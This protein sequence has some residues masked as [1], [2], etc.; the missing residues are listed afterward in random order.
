MFEMRVK[1]YPGFCPKAMRCRISVELSLVPRALSNPT[2]PTTTMLRTQGQHG[3]H[4]DD[5]V[6]LQSAV[7]QTRGDLT[8]TVYASTPPPT[9]R[10]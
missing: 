3:R 1:P 8:H 10:A 7:R 5:T 9:T 2:R 6:R 4:Q